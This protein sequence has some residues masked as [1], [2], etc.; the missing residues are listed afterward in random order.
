MSEGV[1]CAGCCWML[2]L[3]SLVLVLVLVPVLVLLV[4]K[5]ALRSTACI[6]KVVCKKRHKR[7]GYKAHSQLY[8][9]C[10]FSPVVALF[11]L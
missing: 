9:M 4:H 10:N 11:H 8:L 2:L 3:L 6:R 7:K 1:S 5:L